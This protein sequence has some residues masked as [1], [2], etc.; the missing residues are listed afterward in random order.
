MEIKTDRLINDYHTHTTFSHG[1]GSVLENAKKA[2]EL[3]M[4]EIGI[5]EHGPKHRYSKQKE[6]GFFSLKQQALNAS[7]QTGVN[8]LCG[9]EANVLSF[10]GT[11]DCVDV[12]DALDF[13]AVGLHCQ[14]KTNLK[15]FWHLFFRRKLF[16]N[17]KKQKEINTQVMLNVIEKNKD[18]VDFFTHPTRKFPCDI[19]KVAIALKNANIMFELNSASCNLNVE[20]IKQIAQTGV[21]FIIGSD[22]HEPGRI[23]EISNKVKPLLNYINENQ[24]VTK[25]E[26]KLKK[27][28]EEK[29]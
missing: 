9:I 26:P 22:A 7:K 25:L 8:V 14:V 6:K 17:T 16:P 10:D 15:M 11:I 27:L 13:V 20:T 5:C 19:K 4:G 29:N 3:N 28:K 1:V 12:L 23:G 24:I 21:K 2:K 18:Y